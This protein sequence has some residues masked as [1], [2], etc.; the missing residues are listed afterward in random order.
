ML[1]CLIDIDFVVYIIE[2]IYQSTAGRG[3]SASLEET[4]AKRRNLLRDLDSELE[5][6]D[7]GLEKYSASSR[8]R[9]AALDD[10]ALT[11]SL[12]SSARL[13][14]SSSTS[15]NVKKRTMKTTVTTESSRY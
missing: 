4:Y 12:D 11:S 6:I 2:L 9:G 3:S 13:S 1:S 14:S 5:K 15:L 8:A 10:L 7:S